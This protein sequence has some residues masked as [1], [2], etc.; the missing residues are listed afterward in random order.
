PRS[1]S[2]PSPTLFRSIGVEIEPRDHRARAGIGIGRTIAEEFRQNMNVAR[3]Q[4][5]RTGIAAA[6]QDALLEIL[7]DIDAVAL[8]SGLDFSMGRMRLQQM[9][10]RG[11]GRR[12][13]AFVE[14]SEEHT[15]ELQSRFDLV[16]R[17]LLEKKNQ[18]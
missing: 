9:V 13:P 5:S 1:P 3:E 15:S 4:R 8:R 18:A 14:R 16:C 12:L 2:S 11:A 6:R 7:D 17:L 10:D